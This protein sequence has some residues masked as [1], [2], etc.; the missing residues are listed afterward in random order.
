MT[1]VIEEELNACVCVCVVLEPINYTNHAWQ[2][3]LRAK[4]R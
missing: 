3:K 1:S 2:A 4:K